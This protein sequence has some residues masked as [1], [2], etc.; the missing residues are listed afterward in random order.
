MK[1]MHQSSSSSNKKKTVAIIGGGVSGITSC[2]SAIECGLEPTVFEKN[3]VFGGTWSPKFGYT[4]DSMKTNISKYSFM[5][6][7]FPFPKDA[8][9]NPTNQDAIKYLSD[10][11]DRFN[12]LNCFKFNSK[13]LNVCRYSTDDNNEVKW[14]VEWEDTKTGTSDLK[15]IFDFIIV[16]SGFF[17][18]PNPMDES[19][20]KGSYTT[21]FAK[22]YRNPKQ[23][24]GKRVAVLGSSYTGFEIASDLVSSSEVTEPVLQ[25]AYRIPWIIERQIIKDNGESIPID[26][27]FYSRAANKRTRDISDSIISNRNKYDYLSKVSKQLSV[28]PELQV[29]T[30]PEH[31]QSVVISDG[32]VEHVKNKKIIVRKHSSIGKIEGNSIQFNGDSQEYKIDHVIICC[33]YKLRLPFFQKDIQDEMSFQKDDPIQPVL[34]HKTVFPPPSNILKNIAFVGMYKGVF[35]PCVELQAR[36]ICMVF[37]GIINHPS[38]QDILT[39]IERERETRDKKP[40]PQFPRGDFVQFCEELAQQ[41]GAQPDYETIQKDNPELYRKLWN[42]F[43]APSS[44]RYCGYHSNK[45]LS[46]EQMDEIDSLFYK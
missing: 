43:L 2:K 4:W 11:I 46:L 24:K 31:P 38:D 23:F 3:S 8:P 21:S 26:I 14:K 7:D 9:Q 45:E 5:F 35:L 28:G 27:L 33:G 25:I 17:T 29:D 34:L 36:W 20:K 1:S 42:N 44:Y 18:E 19:M 32:Y 16:A 22:D 40:R 12:L 30:P 15:E 37:S 41:I 10:Y 13:V 39:G 6:S